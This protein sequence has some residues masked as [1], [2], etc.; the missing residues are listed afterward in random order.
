MKSTEFNTA[1][2]RKVFNTCILACLTYGCENWSLTKHH[3]DMLS[4]C[5]RAMERSMMSIRKQDK[6]KYTTIRSKTQVT[7]ILTKLDQLKWRWTGHILRSNQE[8]WSKIVTNWYPRDIKKKRGRQHR[9]WEDELKLTAGPD[10]RRVSRDRKQ[11]KMLEEAFAN[12]HTELR[13]IL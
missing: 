13:D 9:R 8:K 3:R 4:Y 1:I 6:I 12:R 2:K 11:W 5:Q 10:W 7:D